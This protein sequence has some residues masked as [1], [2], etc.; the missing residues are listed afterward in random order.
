MRYFIFCL[1]FCLSIS[2]FSQTA[3]I[4]VDA[5]QSIKRISPFIYGR[6]NNLSDNPSSPVSSAN[7]Q[8]YQDAGLRMYREC[9]GNNCTKYNWRLKLSSHPD[10]Y[11]NVYDHDWDYSA[12]SLINNT[13]NTQALFGFQL[14]GKAASN[15]N[16]N[17]NDWAYNNSQYWAGVSNNWAGG[18][19]P[20]NGNPNLYLENWTADSTIGI[21]NHWNALGLD[22]SRLRYWSMDNEPEIW[23]GTHDDVV[24]S[25]TAEQF[26][27]KY[28]AVA[29]AARAKNPT[30]KL[31][32][33]VSP[34]EWQW[35]NWNNSKVTDPNNGK[36][37]SWMEYFIKR[38]AEE[39]Q[40]TGIR[41]LDVLDI[42][43]YPGTQSNPDLTLQLHHLW[44][45]TQWVYPNANGV[46]VTGPTGWDN[47]ITKEY[48]FERCNQWLNQYI[49]SNHGVTFS[50]S[51]YGDI[52]THGSEDANV[53]ACWYASH[54]GTFANNNVELFTPWDW[55]NGQWEVL[56][57]FSNY[58]G[59]FSNSCTSSQETKVSGY[60][61]LSTHGDSLIIAVVNRDRTNAQTASIHLQNFQPSVTTVN[62]HQ[63]ANLGAAETFQSKTSN[64][65]QSLQYTIA[66]NQI[67]LTIPKLSV[68]LIQ[69][70]TNQAVTVPTSVMVAQNI[71]VSVYPN[72]ANNKLNIEI[73]NGED[74]KVTL[75]DMVGKQMGTWN[76]S[77]QGQVDISA[78]PTGNYILQIFQHDQVITKKISKN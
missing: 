61:S 76:F 57:L 24:T 53:V 59:A 36:I 78:F 8:L 3:V 38:I 54:L 1:L 18:G 42:H 29:K 37:Y 7:W 64:A 63:L 73:E 67:S 32:G 33:P 6:N 52:A 30:I 72:P 56:H 60:S 58:F 75:S 77:N 49:G 23:T 65:L 25:I 71:T 16:N 62:A 51:E 21:L 28:F 34:N 5:T 9:G 11:N 14:L 70:P 27:Q 39:Q 2:L 69:I 10:W 46:K 74:F 41:L 45:D 13:S 66:S 68:T 43:F 55:Y 47:T 48:F 4:T 17:F 35:Y 31:I 19:G 20:G 15:K 26:M 22:M 50:I 44:F 40:A 12:T